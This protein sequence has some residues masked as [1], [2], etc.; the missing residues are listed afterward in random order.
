MILIIDNYDSFTYNILHLA[1]PGKEV[2]VVRND[3]TLDEIKRLAPSHIIISS[4]PGSLRNSGINKDLINHFKGK[5]PIM[6][7]GLGHLIICEVFGAKITRTKKI[8]HGKQSYIHIA[9]GSQIFWGLPPIIKAGRYQSLTMDR[10]TIKDDLLIIAEDE[11][12]R[13]MGVKHRKYEIYGLLFH[14]E[15]ILTP[16]GDK[17]IENFLNIGG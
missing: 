8:I 5:I 12:G 17:I 2:K 1:G 15:S 9:N 10:D 6:G 16:H 4:G 3:I 7:I 11:A 14:P 13:L